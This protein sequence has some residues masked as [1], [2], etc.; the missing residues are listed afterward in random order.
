MSARVLIVDD[1]RTVRLIVRRCI[2]QSDLPVEEILEGSNGEDALV[3]LQSQNVHIVLT[4]IN[5][6][7]MDGLQ[8]LIEMK[9]HERWRAIPVVMITTEA[10]SKAVVEAA[11]R[12]AAGYIRKPFTQSQICEQLSPLLQTALQT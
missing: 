10:G 3:Q 7:K 2:E 1:S 8:L 12:G 9:R 5:M 4:D 11:K 6:P